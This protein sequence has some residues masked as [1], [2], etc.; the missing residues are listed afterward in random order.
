VQGRL[1]A[2][3]MQISAS[4]LDGMVREQAVLFKQLK[5]ELE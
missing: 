1:G 3:P 5:D 2:T 4:E